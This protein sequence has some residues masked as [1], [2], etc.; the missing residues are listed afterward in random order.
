MYWWPGRRER[1][2]IG[3]QDEGKKDLE[4]TSEL[5]VPGSHSKA[6]FP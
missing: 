4:H 5:G 6:Y 2:I 1:L 3:E